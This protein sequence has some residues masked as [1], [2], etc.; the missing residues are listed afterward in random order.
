VTLVVI[1]EL[2]LGG[3]RQFGLDSGFGRRLR[4]WRDRQ[5]ARAQFGHVWKLLKISETEVIKKEFS[6]LIE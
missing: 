4:P 6:G 5:V 3:R 2:V 1:A